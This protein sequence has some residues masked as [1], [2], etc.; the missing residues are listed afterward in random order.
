[1]PNAWNGAGSL[2]TS[3]AWRRHLLEVLCR[4]LGA[5]VGCGGEGRWIG[6]ERAFVPVLSSAVD[7]GW[8]GARE[9]EVWLDYMRGTLPAAD[10]VFQHFARLHGRLITRVREQLIQDRDWYRSS[11]FNEQR[12]RSRVDHF[13]NSLHT[14]GRPDHVNVIGLFRELGDPPFSLRERQIA[15]LFHHELGPL[16]GKQLATP[17][18]NPLDGLSPR[19]R[20]TLACLL[21]G[22]GEKQ[23]AA[24]LGLSRPTVHQYVSALYSRFG[25][26]TRS[27][28]LSLWIRIGG[29]TPGSD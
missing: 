27:E 20:Q 22:D 5:K 2:G 11:Q 6:P 23:V 16:V 13:V 1:M 24:R 4:L 26:H 8:A 29:S 18:I 9:R 21:E 25:V 3:E 12:Q 14:L 17:G 15:H 7:L 10:P 19:L 28:L